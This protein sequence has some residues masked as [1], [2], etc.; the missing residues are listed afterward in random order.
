MAGRQRNTAARA[1]A[2]RQDK[3]SA[4]AGPHTRMHA[5]MCARARAHMLPGALAAQPEHAKDHSTPSASSSQAIRADPSA[6]AGPVMWAAR[7]RV[8]PQRPLGHPLANAAARLACVRVS[9]LHNMSSTRRTRPGLPQPGWDKQCRR[10][11]GGGGPRAAPLPSPAAAAAANAHALLQCPAAAAWPLLCCCCLPTTF[12]GLSASRRPPAAQE[13]SVTPAPPA[14]STLH[15]RQSGTGQQR[16]A[17]TQHSEWAGGRRVAS[18]SMAGCSGSHCWLPVSGGRLP[19][20]HL[21]CGGPSGSTRCR[22]RPPR[23]GRC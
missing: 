2:R 11:R 1:H 4:R 14:G 21:R 20:P 15:A 9:C 10:A 3:S 19:Q 18:T 7:H 6:A 8:A 23:S 17:H 12:R 16:R 22:P 13:P 5:C